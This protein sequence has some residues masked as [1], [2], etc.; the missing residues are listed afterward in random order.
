LGRAAAK[1]HLAGGVL[2]VI[3][4]MPGHGQAAL[5]SHKDLPQVSAPLSQLQSHDFVPFRALKDL[6]L[7]MTA[8]IVYAA[9]DPDHPAT[10]SPKMVQVMRGDIGFGGVLISDDLSMN[11]LAGSLGERTAAT[12]SAGVDIALHCNGHM[13]EMVQV[14]DAAGPLTPAA[15]RRCAHALSLRHTPETIDIASLRFDLAGLV[16]G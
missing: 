11:A 5:D 16:A 7:A 12:L 9:I 4:H 15:A 10:T 2:P 6:P 13:D 8:H 3:K 14:T 1:G